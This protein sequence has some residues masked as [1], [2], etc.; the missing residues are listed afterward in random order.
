MCK[1]F[2]DSLVANEGFIISYTDRLNTIAKQESRI[3]YGT[4]H[5]ALATVLVMFKNMF[6][7]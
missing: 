1:S 7:F 6:L 4:A 5:E 2:P 3:S